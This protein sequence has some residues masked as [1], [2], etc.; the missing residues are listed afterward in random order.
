VFVVL[1]FV[2]LLRG[3][4]LAVALR[5]VRMALARR[6]RLVTAWAWCPRALH[7]K[8]H[9]LAPAPCAFLVLR[10]Y[11]CAVLLRRPSAYA[12]IPVIFTGNSQQ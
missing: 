6:C 8:L 7:S 2:E 4:L 10:T 11:C 3:L 5:A 1:R 9:C 12:L